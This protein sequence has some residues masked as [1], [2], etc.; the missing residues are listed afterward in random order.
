MRPWLLVLCAAFLLCAQL[1]M[2]ARADDD[3]ALTPYA[4]FIDGA[5]AQHG[6]F[7]VW[8]KGARPA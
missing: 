2:P 7:T 6:L 3:T 8:R 4:K 5:Q 1:A